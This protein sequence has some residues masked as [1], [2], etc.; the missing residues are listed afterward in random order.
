MHGVV[1]G[2]KNHYG[3]RSE[4]GTEAAALFYSLFGS[5]TPAGVEPDA[6]L[7]AAARLAI[8]ANRSSCLTGS[9]PPERRPIR[10]CAARRKDVPPNHP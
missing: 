10:A 1:V 7:R 3:S 4:R 9:R 5:A 2:R 6:C 8:R